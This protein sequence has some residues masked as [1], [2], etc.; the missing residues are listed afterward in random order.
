MGLRG[1]RD[2]HRPRG[3]RTRGRCGR[4]DLGRGWCH[5][6]GRTG[7]HS[8]KDVRSRRTFL[9]PPRVVG[10]MEILGRRSTCTSR[11][12]FGPVECLSGRRGSCGPQGRPKTVLGTEG[13]GNRPVTLRST[14]VGRGTRRD[15]VLDE[16]RPSVLD[17]WTWRRGVSTGGSW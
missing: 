10:E 1:L 8:G 17:F 7:S 2:H 15:G 13:L 9:V 4:E 5:R 3:S 16:R 6:R 11:Y 12:S 14:M